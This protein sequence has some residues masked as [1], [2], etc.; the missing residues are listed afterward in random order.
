MSCFTSFLLEKLK[1]TLLCK[2]NF[3]HVHQDQSLIDLT[4]L[5]EEM[6]QWQTQCKHTFHVQR[7]LTDVISLYYP[8]CVITC[9]S[10]QSGSQTCETSRWNKKCCGG[11]AKVDTG[12]ICSC[13]RVCVHPISLALSIDISTHYLPLLYLKESLRFYK[14]SHN[15]LLLR[16]PQ[17]TE[18]HQ[19]QSLK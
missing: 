9:L 11:S 8:L 6:W 3:F 2:T 5:R 10:S 16:Q 12:R 13:V 15:A 19:K 1:I 18:W 4:P 7:L 17:F 14:L